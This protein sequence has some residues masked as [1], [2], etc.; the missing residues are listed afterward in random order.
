MPVQRTHQPFKV[1]KMNR[2]KSFTVLVLGVLPGILWYNLQAQSTPA[3][4]AIK[5]RIVDFAT[6]EPLAGVNIEVLD[7]KPGADRRFFFNR[8]NIVLYLNIW[9]VYG[10]E[11]ISG[12]TWNGFTNEKS[13]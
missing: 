12:Y 4:G 11:N 3:G 9:N 1:E 8:S 5:G 7:T 6:R 13:R 2:F 10:R